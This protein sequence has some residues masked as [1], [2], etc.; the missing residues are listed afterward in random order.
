[1]ATVNE[2]Q[3]KLWQSLSSRWHAAQGRSFN[4]LQAYTPLRV[5]FL[6]KCL[7][8]SNVRPSLA[9]TADDKS[10]AGYRILD[11]GCGGGYISEELAKQGAHVVGIDI[12]KEVIK[13]TK[14]SLNTSLMQQ[15]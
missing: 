15:R 7:S 5:Q 9:H 13:V 2:K 1:M 3:E 12:T 11:V 6:R 4:A 10:L 14:R 8:R